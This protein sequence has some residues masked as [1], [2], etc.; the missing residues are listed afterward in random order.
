MK[1]RKR[2]AL[3]MITCTLKNDKYEIKVPCLTYG[4]ANFE[5]QDSDDKYFSFMDK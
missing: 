4:T 2:R 5:R 3:E 1:I